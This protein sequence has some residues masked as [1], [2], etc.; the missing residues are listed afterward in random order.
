MPLE[1]NKVIGA[2]FDVKPVDNTGRVDLSKMSQI[3]PVLHLK[4]NSLENGFFI[5]EWD[6]GAAGRVTVR[7]IKK[8]IPRHDSLDP[9]RVRFASDLER[10]INDEMEPIVTLASIGGI[11]HGNDLISKPRL[12][13]IQNLLNTSTETPREILEQERIINEISKPVS[14]NSDLVDTQL[15][16]LPEEP[17]IALTNVGHGKIRKAEIDLWLENLQNSRTKIDYTRPSRSRFISFGRI[18]SWKNLLIIMGIAVVIFFVAR[19]GFNL[20]NE[21]ISEG[22]AAVK[23]L[24]DAKDKIASM[25]FLGASDSFADAYEEFTKAGEGLNFMGASLGSLI[26]DL[27][28]AEK[29]KSANNLIEAGKLIADSG[30][31]MSKAMEVIS[32]T[33][34]ILNPTTQGGGSIGK[35]LGSLKNGL[36]VSA[37]NLKKA[38]VLLADVDPSALP[39]EKRTVFISMKSE[40]PLFNNLISNSV[41]YAAFLEELVGL[42]GIKRYLL[43]FQNPAELRATGGFPG[44]YATVTF[45]DGSLKQF[46][47]DDV[48][49]LD[50]QLKE[51]II[52]PAQMQHI[53]PTWGMRDA[54]WFVD[55]PTSAKKVAWFYKKESNGLDV[56]GVITISPNIISKILEIVGPID[57]PEYNM[58]IDSKNFATAI[59]SEVEYGENRAQ[60]KKIL[61]D[62][63]PRLLAKIYLSDKEEWLNIFDTFV[64][65]M[66]KKDIL[67]YFKG[68]SL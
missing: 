27:P 47:V 62:M 6:G 11:V 44:S 32:Q 8:N 25:D 35:M 63:A 30:K 49:N 46:I 15:M 23:N 54:N 40:L 37:A 19:H 64:S 26:A 5:R 39:E 36:A 67:M 42:K 68:L 53:T 16:N 59:Q 10:T 21:I 7:V 48:Y 9:K 43:L 50:G 1:K 58:K 60:P 55:F 4:K 45:Q 14:R 33:G 56:D 24:E 22:N 29:I 65:S 13:P 18:L 2:M 12:R 20:K 3:G 28:G 52:P 34:L 41:D 66:E 57:M 51:N 38:E 31:A 17:A 61:M